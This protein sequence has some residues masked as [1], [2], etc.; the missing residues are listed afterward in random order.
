MSS[1]AEKFKAIMDKK[2]ASGRP[3][4]TLH[5]CR[6]DNGIMN[7]FLL[8]DMFPITEDYISAE[9]TI[10]GNHL[11]LTSDRE[12]KIILQKARRTLNMLHRGIR[13]TPT[14]PDVLSIEAALL[15]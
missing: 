12:A 11:M 13:F 8:Q 6:L 2:Q 9:Y 7:A 10:N 3:C 15:K 4:D 5:I 14:Q 1:R